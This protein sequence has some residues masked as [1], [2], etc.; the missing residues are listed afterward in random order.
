MNSNHSIV[1]N[2]PTAIVE[3]S[4]KI[5]QAQS[6]E[7]SEKSGIT[8][9]SQKTE[10]KSDIQEEIDMINLQYNV[11]CIGSVYGCPQKT[12]GSQYCSRF[13]CPYEETMRE[14]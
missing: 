12:N 1:I 9:K 3:I 4:E 6:T 13:Y 2:Q 11:D 10:I 5:I 7:I 8:E 14:Y